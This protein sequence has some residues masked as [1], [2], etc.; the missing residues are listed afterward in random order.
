MVVIVFTGRKGVI[1]KDVIFPAAALAAL[2]L[3]TV[4]ETQASGLVGIEPD[5]LGV[6]V[7]SG[8][9]TSVS[10]LESDDSDYTERGAGMEVGFQ[11]AEGWKLQARAELMRYVAERHGK[12]THGSSAGLGASIARV[13]RAGPVSPYAGFYCGLSYLSPRH[14][15]P[16]LADTGVLAKFSVF[17][18]VE[19]PLKDN[20]SLAVEWFYD[21]ISDIFDGN[22]GGRNHQ[23]FRISLRYEDL[24]DFFDSFRRGRH[25]L[26][27][28]EK[29]GKK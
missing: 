6:Y 25:R 23:G 22:D 1:M 8:R 27:L 14:G 18:G 10:R 5:E 2:L 15:Q 7:I 21:H 3:F 17:A 24:L 26:S 20:Y 4:P 16:E 28:S 19:I 9:E 29:G 11:A 13:I 12:E